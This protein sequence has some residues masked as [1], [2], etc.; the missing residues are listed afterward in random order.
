MGVIEMKKKKDTINKFDRPPYKPP[1]TV[2]RPGSL[3]VLA[4]PS[5]MANT[6]YYPSGKICRDKE[7]P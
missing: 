5:R 3:D 6:L 7:K 4:A 1:K 2:L